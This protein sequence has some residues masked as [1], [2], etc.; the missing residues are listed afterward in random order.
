MHGRTREA[1]LLRAQADEAIDGSPRLVVLY[2]RRRVGKTF[3]TQHL[4]KQ[5]SGSARTVY[6]AATTGA[7]A[8]E[9]RRL[10]G[11]FSEAGVTGEQPSDWADLF[12]R[13]VDHA[14]TEPL[15]VALDEVP[16][17]TAS[18]PGWASA[19]QRA[20]DRAHHQP[21]CHLFMLLT[22]SALHTISSLVSSGGPL[23]ERPARLL[24]LDPFDLPTAASFLGDVAPERVIEAQGACGGYP[25]L[26]Q[27]WDPE[28]AASENLVRLAGDPTGALATNASTLMLDLPEGAGYRRVISAVGRGATRYSEIASHAGQRVD[29]PLQVLEQ[30]GFITRRTPIGEAR[31]TEPKHEID[32]VYLHFWFDV[33]ERDLQL[34][35]GGQGEAVIRRAEKRWNTHLGWVFEREARAHAARLVRHSMLPD[36]MLIGS[37]WTSRPFQAEIDVVGI[38]DNH[39]ELA[40]EAKWSSSIKH[41]DLAPL[42]RA[43]EI[44][45]RGRSGVQLAFWAKEPPTPEV[46]AAVPDALSF[47][48]RDMVA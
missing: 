24:R 27:R 9:R 7:P 37:W 21:P 17:L 2:G 41:A 32:D 4:L 39:W 45:S 44:G 13:I 28:R 6:F 15:V 23:F 48:P 20:W 1:G 10:W 14:A 36:D 22:G 3:L 25:L 16:Y 31:R 34:I 29:R 18:D 33:V 11:E 40:G 43:A 38:R 42:R 19:L 30:A 35:E 8:D 47:T 46:I 12:D 26:L 5:L